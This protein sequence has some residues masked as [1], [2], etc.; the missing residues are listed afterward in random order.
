[1]AYGVS[2]ETESGQGNRSLGNLSNKPLAR[3]SGVSYL[4]D[5][6]HHGQ[7]FNKEYYV[8]V[9][10]EFRKRFRRKRTEIFKS[11]QW[12]LHQ[13]IVYPATN[14]PETE[15]E[16]YEYRYEDVDEMKE[17]VTSTL[18]TFTLED[19]KGASKKWLER[20]KKCITFGGSYCKGD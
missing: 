13:A 15:G 5:R 19:Y 8:E 4:A 6:V 14:A 16:V 10:R 20:Y 18:D 12:H 7:T 3:T 1:M 17:A 9:L 11:G 2:S